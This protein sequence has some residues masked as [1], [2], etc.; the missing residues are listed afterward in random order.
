[1]YLDITS[2][3]VELVGMLNIVIL[4]LSRIFM[5]DLVIKFGFA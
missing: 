4:I 2:K 5:K 3:A 1:M